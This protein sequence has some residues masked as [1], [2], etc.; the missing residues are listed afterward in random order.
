MAVFVRDMRSPSNILF[1]IFQSTNKSIFTFN[2]QIIAI[3]VNLIGKFFCVFLGK[4]GIC[5]FHAICLI[6]YSILK[7]NGFIH[8]QHSKKPLQSFFSIIQSIKCSKPFNNSSKISIKIT[9]K[10]LS[11]III[12]ILCNFCNLVIL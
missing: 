1:H 9:F 12:G 4:R 6:N 10:A 3:F 8:I 5:G 11:I 2:C 7:L